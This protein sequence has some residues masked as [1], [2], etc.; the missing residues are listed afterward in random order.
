MK[1]NEPIK[2]EFTVLANARKIVIVILIALLL[3]S[4]SS[5]FLLKYK[6][7]N[8]TDYSTIFTLFLTVYAIFCGRLYYIISK[9][10]ILSLIIGILMIVL[11]WFFLGIG[12]L[13]LTIYLLIKSNRALKKII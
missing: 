11:S 13:I 4:F 5:P 12:T 8:N 6:I 2:S 10:I 1:I 7:I 9:N 3:F